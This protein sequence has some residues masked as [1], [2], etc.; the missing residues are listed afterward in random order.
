LYPLP[1]DP[2]AG[3]ALPPVLKTTCSE[4]IFSL[5]VSISNKSFFLIQ[6]T[7]VSNKISMFL[8]S[9]IF[10]FKTSTTVAACSVIG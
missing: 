10:N 2:R 1:F 6:M 8:H 5:F 9:L 3:Y 4:I 7:S